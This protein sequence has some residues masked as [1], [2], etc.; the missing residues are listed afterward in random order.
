MASHIGLPGQVEGFS[1]DDAPAAPAKVLLDL[2]AV[3][4]TP[5]SLDLQKIARPGLKRSASQIIS[6]SPAGVAV[7]GPPIADSSSD[8][9]VKQATPKKKSKQSSTDTDDAK[10]GKHQKGKTPQ[11]EE[12]P[13]TN[14]IEAAMNDKDW[15]RYVP[16]QPSEEDTWKSYV[17]RR[18]TELHVMKMP[19]IW[20]KSSMKLVA[21]E[22]RLVKMTP[23]AGEPSGRCV[24]R[25]KKAKASAEDPTKTATAAA[26]QT[27]AMGPKTPKKTANTG[28][29]K[30]TKGKGSSWSVTP[31]QRKNNKL[32]EKAAK[33]QA[34]ISKLEKISA[35][36]QQ[37]I[38]KLREKLATL[39]Q[40][41]S[42]P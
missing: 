39:M 28:K 16:S 33:V 10:R 38:G 29:K 41:T 27:P 36:V 8:M 19:K 35:R 9:P 31:T 1:D 13:E 2:G 14:W 6:E 26:P 18:L 24:K 7:V 17:T 23:R 21:Q 15:G 25:A 42:T 34:G 4:P 32:K 11:K 30:K 40:G 20:T 3:Q 5:S 12:K 22:Y 37:Q